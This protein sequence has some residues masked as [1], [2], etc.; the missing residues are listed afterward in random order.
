VEEPKVSE[1]LLKL[2]GNALNAVLDGL[3]QMDAE[4]R[5]R[6]MRMCGETCARE[7]Y[8]GPALEIAERIAREETDMD[9][10][11]ERVNREISWCGRWVRLGRMIQSTCRECGC[12][13][14]RHGVV[15]S[16]GVFCHCSVG[17][18]EAVFGALLRR[19]VRVE[20]EKAIGLG[21]EECRYV[22]HLEGLP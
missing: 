3:G 12:P 22:V 13:L 5:L 4:T 8:W 9:R 19:P 14:V 6:I 7:P 1:T 21:D 2:A 16:T 15:R 17:W 11:L 18:V 10:C 20:L